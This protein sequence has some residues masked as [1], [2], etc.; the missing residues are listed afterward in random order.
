MFLNSDGSPLEGAC[1]NYEQDSLCVSTFSSPVDVPSNND[2]EL[3][4]FRQQT[5]LLSA[6]KYTYNDKRNMIKVSSFQVAGSTPSCSL[7][8]QLNNKKVERKHK[9]LE[10]V[11]TYPADSSF[12]DPSETMYKEKRQRNNMAA[13]KSRDAR[14]IRE[15]QLKVKVVCL[16]N[17]NEILRNQVHREK[18]ENRKQSSKITVLEQQ[19]E[20]TKQLKICQHCSTKLYD[21]LLNS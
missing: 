5:N 17:A 7:G 19:I 9:N 14:K 18:D 21:E 2:T 16:E 3:E 6:E 10:S 13:K 20:E 8:H 11:K 1:G 15:N 4:C 12:E